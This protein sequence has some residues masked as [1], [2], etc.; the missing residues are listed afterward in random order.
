MEPGFGLRVAYFVH[1]LNDPAVGRR[2]AMLQ[3]GGLEV[4]PIG[5]WR[6]SS[7]PARIEGAPVS[8]LARTYD[9]RLFHRALTTIWSAANAARL[10]SAAP[11]ADLILARNLE[12][13]ALAVASRRARAREVPIVY[14]ALDIHAA[15]LSRRLLGRS[16]RLVEHAL[17]RHTDLLITSSP[18]FVK[19]YFEPVHLSRHPTP[20]VVI[21]NK[22][23]DLGRRLGRGD[24]STLQPGPPWRIGWFGVIRCRRSFEALRDLARRRPDLARIV[25]HGRPSEPVFPDFA[26]EIADAGFEFGG[27]YARGDLGRLYQSV[28]FNWTID[29]Y[30]EGGNSDWLLPN[31]LYEGSAFGTTPIALRRTATGRRLEA[32][33]IGALM[34]DPAAELEAFLDALTPERHEAM[35]LAARKV[36]RG[37]F[38]ADLSDCDRLAALLRDVAT[39]RLHADAVSIA[40]QPA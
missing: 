24:A 39:R 32:L 16:L 21:E 8:P 3:A 27:T 6:G 37:A 13:L 7:A 38:I 35:R 15:M 1:D 23:L 29:W 40:S 10:A 9:S 28:H 17:L 2:I 19:N 20:S 5:F 14:E 33:G 12:M 34:D 26:R 30:E 11:D 25:L 18:W 31:R 4:A 22:L 36:P